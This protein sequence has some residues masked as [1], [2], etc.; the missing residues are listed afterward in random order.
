MKVSKTLLLIPVLVLAVT[1]LATGCVN[2]EVID[3]REEIELPD[4]PIE[5]AAI[6]G[7]FNAYKDSTMWEVR[8]AEAIK[9]TPTVPTKDFVREQDPKELYCVCVKYEARYKVPW[10]TGDESPWEITRRNILVIKTQGD[11]FLA[12]RPVGLCHPFCD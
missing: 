6:L 4:N 1:L 11:V 8:N 2:V 9:V 7:L 10:T 3:K 5:R 12:M